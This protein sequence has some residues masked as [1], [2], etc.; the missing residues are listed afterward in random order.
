MFANLTLNT[1]KIPLV[2]END[3]SLPVIF[4]RLVFCKSGRAYDAKAGCAA[5]LA[6]LLNEGS[7]ED[8]F[9]ELE[10]RAINLA[11]SS[12]FESFELN[13]SC[14]KEHFAFALEKL[15]LLLAK[16]LFEEKILQRI[17]MTALGE[18]AARQSDFDFLAKN[19]LN[20]AVFENEAFQSPNEG[21][22]KSIQ[23]LNLNDLQVFFKE[24][25]S[26]DTLIVCGGGDITQSE[27]EAKIAPLLQILPQNKF[28]KARHFDFCKKSKDEVLIK[29][30]SE[31]A[32][33]Y[34]ASPFKARVQDENLYLAKIALFI[35]GAGGF[36][37]R[38][39]EEVR[40]K[41]GLAYSAYAMLDMS[42]SYERIFG[43]LQTKNE[44]AKNAKELIQ[45][46]FEGFFKKGV[47]Q[48]ELESAKKFL[49]GSMPLRYESLEK[50][51]DIALKERYYE[52][53]EG[54]FKREIQKIQN[55][56]LD[57]LNFFIKAHKEASNLS[58][59]S[60]QKQ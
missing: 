15:A 53:D 31:Q 51:L 22:E 39:M 47:N 30:Q 42:L 7:G 21:D 60:V 50:R 10:L 12:G 18:L 25:L 19:L 4:L 35:L 17:K 59:A 48:N 40:V 14:L 52:L 32:Y 36:G 45:E 1:S 41:R 55:T 28:I 8:F 57:E 26:L 20:C 54:Y 44:N 23:S 37:S 6:R 38:I 16:P 11:A 49:T 2:F 24:H 43:Y 58:F 56:S 27:F 9:E 3:T 5:L 29:K 34:F 33:I 46:L 13:M